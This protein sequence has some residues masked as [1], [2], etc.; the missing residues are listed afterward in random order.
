MTIDG[1]VFPS[2]DTAML[3]SYYLHLLLAVGLNNCAYC[4]ILFS[5]KIHIERVHHEKF[6]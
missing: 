2:F 1:E 5:V 6:I 3:N 4:F